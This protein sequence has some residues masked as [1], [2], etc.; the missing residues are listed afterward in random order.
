M[1]GTELEQT[2][3]PL[4]TQTGLQRAGCVVNAGMDYATV[5][6][7]LALCRIR[8]PFQDADPE[9][10]IAIDQCTN[11]RQAHDPGPDDNHVEDIRS[12]RQHR[13]PQFRLHANA[14][15]GY[16]AVKVHGAVQTEPGSDH[17]PGE[18]CP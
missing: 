15:P 9:S 7:G 1:P 11:R 14:G 3:T 10:G 4:S 5:M 18:V 13:T 16:S 2:G 17:P 6:S 12:A 8:V